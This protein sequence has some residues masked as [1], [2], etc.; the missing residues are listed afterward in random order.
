MARHYFFLILLGLTCGY[1]MLRGSKDARLAAAVCVGATLL[2]HFAIQPIAVRFQ[3]L[4]LGVLV[5]DLMTFI[6]FVLVALGSSRFWPLWIAGL[7]LTSSLSHLAR[8]LDVQLFPRAY[9]V[10]AVFWSY[11]ILLILL[12]GTW[13][14]V[15]RRNTGPSPALA[16]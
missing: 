13:R 14:S 2:T 1:A 12:V 9:A 15:R 5:V 11:P 3:S 16:G 6:G 7:Q 10:A 4:E 8:I